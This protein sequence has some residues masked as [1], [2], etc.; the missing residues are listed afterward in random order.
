MVWDPGLVDGQAGSTEGSPVTT[1][2]ASEIRKRPVAAAVAGPA[3]EVCDFT[4]YAFYA[5]RIGR[6]FNP[7]HAP[8]GRR[9][10]PDRDAAIRVR[11]GAD[12]APR[13]AT[14]AGAKAAAG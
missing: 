14:E 10:R 1:N 5:V 9:H 7:S 12:R 11:S 13:R 2:P 4:A 6:A 8:L 3:P